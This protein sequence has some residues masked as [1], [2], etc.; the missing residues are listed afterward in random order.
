[1]TIRTV[2]PFSREYARDYTNGW[3]VS[4]N[5]TEGCLERADAREVSHAWY[6]GYHDSA[7]GRPKW[8][9]RT[10][11]RNGCDS[12]CG[13][14]CDG[15]HRPAQRCPIYLM[16]GMRCMRTAGHAGDCKPYE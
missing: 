5:W 10:W 2:D 11:R 14:Q 1:M 3:N 8:T 4:E 7:A 16:P 13:Y 9:Y 6:D 12:D 15:P